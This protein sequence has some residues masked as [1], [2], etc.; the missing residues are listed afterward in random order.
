[1]GRGRQS[2]GGVV[3]L[4]CGSKGLQVQQGSAMYDDMA[5][6]HYTGQ[7]HHSLFVEFIPPKEFVV[8]PG[9]CAFQRYCTCSMRTR[10]TA[11]GTLSDSTVW[12][13]PGK[14]RFMRHLRLAEC[15]C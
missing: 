4:R 1:M 2:Y 10:Y 12:C 11:S 6:L 13:R 9:L 15:S 3:P 7:S 5:D 8:V 14:R